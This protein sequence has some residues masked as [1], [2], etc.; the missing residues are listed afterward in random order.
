MALPMSMEDAHLS[1]T[2]VE[3]ANLRA[4]DERMRRASD[5][6]A[7]ALESMVEERDGD[8]LP[9]LVVDCLS[10]ALD[11]PSVA[12]HACDGTGRAEACGARAEPGFL[13]L[14]AKPPFLAY[15]SRKPSRVVADTPVLVAALGLPCPQRLP[16]VLLCG[17]VGPGAGAPPSDPGWLV[18]C[19]GVRRLADPEAQT[20]FRRFLPV[21]THA[22]QRYLEGRRAE[23]LAS[24]EREMLLA[25]E[26]A[27]AA[28]RAKS[29]F[30][31]RMS[32]EL[33]T[34]L[35]AIIGFA[36]L[37]ETEP[38]TQIQLDQVRLIASAGD[39][40]LELVNTVLDQ[41]R[42]EAGKLVLEVV[43]FDLPDLVAAVATM[44]DRQAAAKGLAFETVVAPDLPRRLLGD[45]T[46][47]RQV[48]INLLANAV[49][50]TE[51][52]SVMLHL[53]AAEG[54]LEFSVRDTGMGMDE[55]ARGRIFQAFSQADESVARRFGGTG[56]GLLITRDLLRAMGGDMVVES[57]PGVGSCFKGRLPLRLAPDESGP[58]PTGRP[59]PAQSLRATARLAGRRV[60]VVDDNAVNRTLATALL[61]RMG[62]I[63]DSADDGRSALVRIAAGGYDLVLMD[64]EMP[65]MDGLSA[66]R[67]L[68]SDEAAH[69]RPSLPVVALTANAMAEDRARCAAAG[70]DGYVAKPIGVAQ[71]RA[72]LERLLPE[73]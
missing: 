63:V 50:F 48:L 26:R 4:R 15:L 69:G 54:M 2:L 21:V 68:R 71:L 29:E 8:R 66:T 39:H 18:L 44:I 23:E 35:T 9:Q 65:G 19:A 27:E 61:E 40:L 72:E 1:D 64:M 13:E 45:P 43:A 51:R 12:I 46:R 70:M 10:R 16:P 47:L 14:L 20:L 49:K 67:A 62:I 5:A 38:L 33:R 42:I 30:L 31:S 32:H 56:L 6:L 25:K 11:T 17:R 28:S 7:S 34:P 58:A 37:L 55:A 59:D 41:A 24:R 73:D 57:A 52:G 60:L 36:Q 53:T 22:L 3:L